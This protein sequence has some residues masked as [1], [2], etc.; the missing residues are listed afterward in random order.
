MYNTQNYWAFG[1]CSSSGTL[2]TRERFGSWICF[3]PQ[4][5]G[6][7][8]LWWVPYN[9]LT[10]ITALCKWPNRVGVSPHL[11]PQT[12]AVSETSRSLVF[13]IPDSGQVKK[14]QQFC[15]VPISLRDRRAGTPDIQNLRYCTYQRDNLLTEHGLDKLAFGRRKCRQA[16][17]HAEVFTA[18]SSNS[19]SLFR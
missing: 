10:S 1:L 5:R 9:E 17:I 3:R 19:I 11:R 16:T 7:H 12:N 14:T 4:V 13:R 15:P 8:L 6:R 18:I 2:K